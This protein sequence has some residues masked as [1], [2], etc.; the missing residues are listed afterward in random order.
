MRLALGS[1]AVALLVCLPWT[2]GAAPV[3][4]V[5]LL[6]NYDDLD[7]VAVGYRVA[8]GKNSQAA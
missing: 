8:I 1:T 7:R 6:V 5:V 3:A 2:I 4:Q